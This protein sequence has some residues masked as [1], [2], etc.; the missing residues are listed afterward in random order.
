LRWKEL[1]SD[2]EHRR[3]STWAYRWIGSMWSE[4]GLCVSPNRNLVTYAGYTEGTNSRRR[5]Q[6]SEFPVEA[7]P[8][9]PLSEA[10]EIDLKADAYLGSQVFRGTPTGVI[11][12]AAESAAMAVLRRRR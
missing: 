6:W 8:S 7:L 4:R 11:R 2:A 5:A 10:I 3:V 1:F 9:E 12:G